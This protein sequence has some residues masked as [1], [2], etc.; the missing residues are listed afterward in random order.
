V[1]FAILI[2]VLLKCRATLL[3][4]VLWEI[5]SSPV[6]AKA[7]AA[8]GPGSSSQGT[9]DMSGGA[10]QAEQGA[11]CR[12]GGSRRSSSS[13]TQSGEDL[14]VAADAQMLL[15]Y[16]CVDQDQFAGIGKAIAAVTKSAASS[17][18]YITPEQVQAIAYPMGGS[19]HLASIGRCV[20]SREEIAAA[21]H[22]AHACRV[23]GS[24]SEGGM[25]PGR[26]NEQH[27]LAGDGAILPEHL[28]YGAAC[29]RVVTL[30][31]G[32]YKWHDVYIAARQ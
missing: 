12:E 6:A 17:K 23:S 15:L 25:P 1:V 3:K 27:V 9:S 19:K 22:A 10:I 24:G 11:E 29:E 5:F 20:L 8:A 18:C 21:V 4:E 14:P 31:L 30:L 13:T 7:A 32:R 2:E 16:L 28:M 26:V